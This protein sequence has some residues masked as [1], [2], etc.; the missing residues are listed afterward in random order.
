MNS[1]RKMHKNLRQWLPVGKCLGP[2]RV[3]GIG[4]R[5]FPFCT[6]NFTIL[7]NQL[8]NNVNVKIRKGS[9]CAQVREK[10]MLTGSSWEA[11]WR[12]WHLSQDTQ[13]FTRKS[14][15]RED[16]ISGDETAHLRLL[17]QEREWELGG[18]YIVWRDCSNVWVKW[19]QGR[20]ER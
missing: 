9:M 8:V 20:G 14:Y 19:G 1:F 4:R 17:T 16:H 11:S 2:W 7:G 5:H 10:R 18:C 12:R 6:L 3:A 13:N 15:S